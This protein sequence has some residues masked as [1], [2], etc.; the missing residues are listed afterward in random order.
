MSTLEFTGPEVGGY[1][2]VRYWERK[3]KYDIICSLTDY[4]KWAM[5]MEEE[6][7]NLKARIEELENQKE[8][9]K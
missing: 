1:G 3:T 2:W 9:P 5:R 6:N 4:A 8:T 7:K